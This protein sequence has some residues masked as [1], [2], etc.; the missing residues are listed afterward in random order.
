M[1]RFQYTLLICLIHRLTGLHRSIKQTLFCPLQ[2]TKKSSIIFTLPAWF[3][4]LSSLGSKEFSQCKYYVSEVGKRSSPVSKPF[5]SSY[6]DGRKDLTDC[7]PLSHTLVI[8]CTT[9]QL[10]IHTVMCL[11]VFI[12]TAIP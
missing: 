6:T 10:Y 7:S 11:T 1:K 4:F 3:Q 9:S 8:I 12:I 2:V 5:S